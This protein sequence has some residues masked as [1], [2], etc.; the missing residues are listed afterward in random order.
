[1]GLLALECSPPE[2]VMD[3]AVSV[4]AC[5]CWSMDLCLVGGTRIL[6][7]GWKAFCSGLL[8][9]YFLPTGSC[10][11]AD[12]KGSVGDPWEPEASCSRVPS[13]SSKVLRPRGRCCLKRGGRLNN[14]LRWAGWSA[15]DKEDELDEDESEFSGDCVLSFA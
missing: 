11:A 9:S 6:R 7:S 4:V 15:S 13:P 10:L 12:A 14:W 2:L 3:D 5:D 8:V 1:M